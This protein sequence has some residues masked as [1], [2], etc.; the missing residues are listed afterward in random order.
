MDVSTLKRCDRNRRN[1]LTDCRPFSS[2]LPYVCRRLS[3][4]VG[5][6]PR[7][8][9]TCWTYNDRRQCIFQYGVAAETEMA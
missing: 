4:S 8:V 5:V 7:I 1:G 9:S 2:F 6:S 3:A